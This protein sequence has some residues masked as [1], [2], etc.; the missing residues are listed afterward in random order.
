MPA[1]RAAGIQIIW[2]QNGWD[3]DYVEAG[4]A[5]SPNFRHQ[6]IHQRIIPAAFRQ[7][8]AVQFRAFAHGFQRIRFV[9]IG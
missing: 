8:R 4:D 7:Q 5:G 2:F 9:K 3:A 6:L 1:A